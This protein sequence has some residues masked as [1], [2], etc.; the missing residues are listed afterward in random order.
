MILGVQCTI[1]RSDG[2]KPAQV[3]QLLSTQLEQRPLHLPQLDDVER[4]AHELEKRPSYD[5][6]PAMGQTNDEMNSLRTATGDG[7]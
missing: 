7:I 5:A 1:F 4:V 2:L 6:A 3:V